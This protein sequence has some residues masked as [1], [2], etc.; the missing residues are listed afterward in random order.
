MVL[1]VAAHPQRR[2]QF[3]V[4]HLDAEQGFQPDSIGPE[5]VGGWIAGGG[6]V[7]RVRVAALA[8][9]LTTAIRTAERLRAFLLGLYSPFLVESSEP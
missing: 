9:D 1:A 8:T 3:V 5:R 6:D 7:A 4:A 2:R